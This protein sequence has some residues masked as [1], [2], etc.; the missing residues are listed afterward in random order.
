MPPCRPQNAF[1]LAAEL[2]YVTGVM[3]AVSI[4]SPSLVPGGFDL[5][6]GGHVGHRAAGGHVGQHD[7]HALAAALGQLLGPIGQDVGRLGHEVHAAE[8]DA[9]AIAAVGGHLAE[10]IAVAAQVGEGDHLVLLIVMAQNQQ[11]RAQAACGRLGC[12]PTARRSPATCRASARR[13]AT[14]LEVWSACDGHVRKGF[15]A[16]PIASLPTRQLYENWLRR[17]NG[18][19]G[20]YA[21]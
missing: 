5:V 11:L 18:L 8:D 2:M 3:S 10:L 12:A 14:T 13:W 16:A 7:G 9:A 1:R 6:D 15:A 17:A 21:D 20:Q 19:P 4:T